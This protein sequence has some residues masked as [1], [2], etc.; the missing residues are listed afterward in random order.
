MV[1]LFKICDGFEVGLC[2]IYFLDSGMVGCMLFL[3]PEIL[4]PNG[5]SL[6]IR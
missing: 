2:L 1:L 4:K 6:V 5:A 3:T